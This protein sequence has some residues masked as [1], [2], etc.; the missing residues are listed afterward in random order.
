MADFH[1]VLLAQLGSGSPIAAVQEG[2]NEL[3]CY[4]S[5]TLPESLVRVEKRSRSTFQG[6]EARPAPLQK[7]DLP[8]VLEHRFTGAVS[9]RR[10]RHGES[11]SS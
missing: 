6:G 9:P 4:A 7:V 11:P 10:M 1:G 5:A 3:R 2:R 8:E